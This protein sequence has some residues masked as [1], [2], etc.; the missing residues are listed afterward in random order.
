MTRANIR[1]VR[2]TGVEP[3]TPT[4]GGLYSIHLSYKRKRLYIVSHLPYR[5]NPTESVFRRVAKGPPILIFKD[6]ALT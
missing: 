4:F 3:A 2:L 6:K 1:M 5:G